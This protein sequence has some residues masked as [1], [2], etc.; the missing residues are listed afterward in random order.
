M[1]KQVARRECGDGAR[2]SRRAVRARLSCSLRSQMTN[3]CGIAELLDVPPQD[4]DAERVER[5]D[6]GRWRANLF[7]TADSRLGET[8]PRVALPRDSSSPA[9]SC[10][11]PAAFFVNVTARIRSGFT[12]VADQ[13][14]DAIGDHARLAGAGAGQHQ[15]RP[16]ERPHGV[17]LGGFRAAGIGIHFTSWPGQWAGLESNNC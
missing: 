6:F 13:L 1:R 16:L 7:E 10:I 14:G 9:R 3:F 4:A 11:S 5:G 17:E 8:R 2:N 15:Q 12:A